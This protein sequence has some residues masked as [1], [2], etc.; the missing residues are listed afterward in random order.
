MVD[1]AGD[2]VEVAADRHDLEAGPSPGPAGRDHLHR[3]ATG[4]LAQQHLVAGEEGDGDGALLAETGPPGAAAP[5]SPAPA[6][7]P[8]AVTSSVATA[9]RM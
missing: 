3:L 4:P 7:G 1:V 2:D 9:T 5:W 6:A 8:G